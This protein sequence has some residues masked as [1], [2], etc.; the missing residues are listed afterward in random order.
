[1]ANP[2]T[3]FGFRPIKALSGSTLQVN[4]YKVSSSASRIGKG[5]LVELNSSGFVQRSTSATSVGPWIGVAAIDGGVPAAGGITKFPVFDD[6]SVIYE[7]MSASSIAITTTSLNQIYKVNCGTAPNSSTGLSQ[8]QVTTTLATASNG[9]RLLRIVDAP[10]VESG[11][12]QRV[13]VKLNAHS[14]AP[15]TAGV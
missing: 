2:S 11:A 12:N 3:P 6:P 10:D 14:N 5:D 1:M 8:D 9:V 4:Y 15:G 7:A 13:E